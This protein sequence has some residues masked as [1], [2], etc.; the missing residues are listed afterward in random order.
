MDIKSDMSSDVDSVTD[1]GEFLTLDSDSDTRFLRTSDTDSD[2]VMTS[3]TDT[4]SDTGID[5]G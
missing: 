1:P 4:T 3:D 5:R 2:K